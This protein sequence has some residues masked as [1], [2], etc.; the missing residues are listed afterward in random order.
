M[1]REEKS[2]LILQDIQ[3]ETSRSPIEI[4]MNM[5]KKEYID[6]N[7]PEHHVLDGACLL[8]AY[9]NAGGEVDIQEYLSKMLKEGLRMPGAMCG[10]WG[11]CGAVTSVGAALCIIDGTTPYTTDGT[12]GEHM[13]AFTGKTL[14]SMGKVNGPRCCKRNGTLA[15]FHA[16]NYVNE[17]YGVTLEKTQ[18]I[19]ETSDLNKECIK[20]RCPYYRMRK[21]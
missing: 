21:V 11:V 4:F 12:W 19:C 5:S 7:G 20:E 18:Y 9:K 6:P 17:H 8:M 13:T 15:L 10:L 1:T 14:T 16:T 3:K 2:E